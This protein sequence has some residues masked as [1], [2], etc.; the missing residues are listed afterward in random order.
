VSIEKTNVWKIAFKSK[1][2]LFE[3]LVIPFGLTNA[4]DAFMQMMDDILRPFTKSFVV[5]YLDDLQIFIKTWEDHLE[6]IQQVLGTLWQHKLYANLEKCS[7]G[8]KTIQ[9]FGY[10]MDEKGVHVDLSKIQVIHDLPTPKTMTE[11]HNFFGLAKFYRWFVLGFSHITWSLVQVI[12]DG[13]TNNVSWSSPQQKSF[14]DLQSCLY[15]APVL[16]LSYLQQPFEI[17]IDASDYPIGT[18]LTQNGHLVAYHSETL[19]DVVRRY[20]TYEKEMYSI[21]QECQQW[22]HYILGKETIIH[23]DQRPLEF[24]LTQ[25]K[26]QNDQHHKWS[27]YLQKFHLNIKYKKDSTNH[28]TD[29]LSRPPMAALTKIL[30]SSGHET[31]V[32]KQ[33]YNNDSN[34]VTAYQTLSTGKIVPNFHLWDGLLCHLSHLC[35]PSSEC[36]NLI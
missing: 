30:N 11:I 27:M 24:M 3:W 17:D 12:K 14:E 26:L 25:G 23:I 21:V 6:H 32:W 16:I 22:K 9:Y 35:V 13:T 33:L 2:G 18:V 1:E 28:V 31:S 4:P 5:V 20:P 7:F 10:I 34:F 19:S 36:E 29:F 15:S 8:M